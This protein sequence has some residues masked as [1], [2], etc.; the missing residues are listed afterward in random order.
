M[1]TAIRVDSNY[2]PSP[3][4]RLSPAWQHFRVTNSPQWTLRDHGRPAVA[5]AWDA[6][7]RP[8][9]RATPERPIPGRHR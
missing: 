5:A 1:F 3:E 4:L 7:T 9:G 2:E 8:A 6:V